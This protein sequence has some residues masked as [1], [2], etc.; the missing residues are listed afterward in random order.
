MHGTKAVA[1]VL[2]IK[3]S[4]IT[5]S[6]ICPRRS[7]GES[8]FIAHVVIEKAAVCSGQ[9]SSWDAVGEWTV[10]IIRKAVRNGIRCLLHLS[11]CFWKYSDVKVIVTQTLLT[12]T[13]CI[14]MKAA[15]SIV[16]FQ[17]GFL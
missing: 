6:H 1:L 15:V 7:L 10:G 16:D 8:F 14:L 13:L 3:I 11:K 9:T 17:D 5:G 4:V 12:E 2:V